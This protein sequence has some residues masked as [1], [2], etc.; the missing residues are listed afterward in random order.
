MWCTIFWNINS[1][2]QQKNEIY[3]HFHFPPKNSEL[4]IWY[5]TNGGIWFW[6]KAGKSHIRCVAAASV[7][8]FPCWNIDC[9]LGCCSFLLS[10][11]HALPF[12]SRNS[13]LNLSF[14]SSIKCIWHAVNMTEEWT[15]FPLKEGKWYDIEWVVKLNGIVL[16]NKQ[17]SNACWAHLHPLIC[18]QYIPMLKYF[19]TAHYLPSTL[20]YF[21]FCV[22]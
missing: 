10:L 5:A 19:I 11:H 2:T 1:L 4:W 3:Q 9:L 8:S 6:T 22:L 15:P 17:T 14:T 18:F 20:H 7:T 13:S 12:L 16:H 21:F